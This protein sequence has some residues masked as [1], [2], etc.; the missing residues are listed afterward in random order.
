MTRSTQLVLR[1][2][3]CAPDR[4]Y[5]RSRSSSPS[6]SVPT[7]VDAARGRDADVRPRAQ[8]GWRALDGAVD[9][10]RSRRSGRTE[11][12][13]ALRGPPEPQRRRRRASATPEASTSRTP[14]A[15]CTTRPRARPRAPAVVAPDGRRQRDTP[16]PRAAHGPARAALRRSEGSP[17]RRRGAREV[18][19]APTTRS[20]CATRS[21]A[22]RT[23]SVRKALT[24]GARRARPRE[25]R[26]RSGAS[27][28]SPPSTPRAPSGSG[29]SSKRW[30]RST[31]TARIASR[32]RACV[33]RPQR[34]VR[35]LARKQFVFDTTADVLYGLS[36]GSIL[37]LSSLGLA[38]T[39]GLMRV[40]NM[41][42]GEMLMLGAYATY[43]TQTFF[44]AHFP[45]PRVV[46]PA[47]RRAGRARR[48]PWPSARSSSARSSGFFTGVRSRR[49]SRPTGSA[50]S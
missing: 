49:S 4:G 31:T 5:A 14:A 3:R 19:R 34:V 29:R 6:C 38:I 39:F 10:R 11:D 42:H 17:R 2:R 43:A 35:S 30:P 37:L 28:P 36:M 50:S 20:P 25:R 44:H 16:R 24:V 40:I 13:R 9:A 23:K 32:I 1:V 27:A 18:A 47:R 45:R 12:P 26:S 41:A 15:R 33:R 46:V 8:A 22:R 7:V 48:R 21:R